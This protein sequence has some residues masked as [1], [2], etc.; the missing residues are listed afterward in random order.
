VRFGLANNDGG[1]GE[2]VG[3]RVM[4]LLTR[5][6]RGVVVAVMSNVTHADTPVLAQRV[7]A[8]FTR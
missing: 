8:A 4:S 5:P 1:D 6:D 2:L 7:A 3:G